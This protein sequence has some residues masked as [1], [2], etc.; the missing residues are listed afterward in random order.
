MPDMTR[1]I[2]DGNMLLVTILIFWLVGL[3]QLNWVLVVQLTDES[4]N[5]DGKVMRI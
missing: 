5:S 1:D 4:A 3:E 2:G